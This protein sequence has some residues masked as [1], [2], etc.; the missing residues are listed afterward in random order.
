MQHHMELVPG[1]EEIALLGAEAVAMQYGGWDSQADGAGRGA[2]M[3]KIAA[4]E[5]SVTAI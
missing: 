3:D 5:A 4:Q 2:S 1:P